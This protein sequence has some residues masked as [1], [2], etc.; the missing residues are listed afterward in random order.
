MLWQYKLAAAAKKLGKRVGLA[1]SIDIAKP[2]QEA[3]EQVAEESG[4]KGLTTNDTPALLQPSPACVKLIHSFESCA[5]LRPDGLY[6][7]YP[8]PGSSNGEPWTI[9]WGS[10]GKGIGPGT[11]WTRAQCD[12][13]FERDL[14]RFAKGVRGFIGDTPTTQGQFDALVSFHYNTG[15]IANSTLGRKH[16]AGDYAGAA[17]QFGRWIYNDGVPMKGLKR[18]R[19]AEREL[20]ES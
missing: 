19:Q 13:R 7:A 9:G 15:A 1:P 16:K 11:R 18:R 20:Y 5:V 3:G 14:E 6:E 17:A 8:D 4:A 12:A 10:T 2:M